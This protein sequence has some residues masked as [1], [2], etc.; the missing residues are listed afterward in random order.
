MKLI[1]VLPGKR[2]KSMRVQIADILSRYIQGSDSLIEEIN[3]NKQVGPVQACSDLAQK[4]A[5]GA[6]QYN[7]MPHVSYVYATKT[8]AFPGLLKIGKTG[9]LN[10]RLYGLNTSCAPLPHVFVAIAPT[11]DNTRDE[12]AFQAFFSVARREGE[13]FELGE[14]D[15]IAY[16]ASHIT[17]QFNVELAEHMAR[18]PPA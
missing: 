4:A 7:A 14:A 10:A 6:S 17:A 18:A 5:A 16:F 12:K 9:D 11:F 13:F 1:M 8:P 2:A 15:L 3:H